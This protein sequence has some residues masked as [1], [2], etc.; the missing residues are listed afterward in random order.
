MTHKQCRQS[1]LLL[2]LFASLPACK[3][4]PQAEA[5]EARKIMD[6]LAMEAQLNILALNGRVE[7]GKNNPAYDWVTPFEQ[8]TGCEVKAISVDN[9]DELLAKLMQ[10]D[11]DIVIST[12]R[13]WPAAA[14]IK[15]IDYS[16]LRSASSIAPRFLNDAASGQSEKFHKALPLQW[17][18]IQP[19]APATEVITVV[20]SIRLRANAKNINCAYAWMEWSLSPKV[21]AE[22][23]SWI[24]TIPVVP[25][26]CIGNALLGN[27]ACRTR[28]QEA[29]A[30]PP[31]E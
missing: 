6:P 12:D 8:A 4:G 27:D 16:R 2:L 9:H 25:T 20:E 10:S 28:E 5:N 14:S 30:E 18:R 24:G 19:P 26:A 15:P 23:A 13:Q 17:Q 22:V 7:S 29:L 11:A 1:I 21:Q 31:Q 3:K